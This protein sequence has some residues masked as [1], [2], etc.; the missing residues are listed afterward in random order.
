[1]SSPGR[2]EADPAHWSALIGT[3]A[4]RGDRD[5]FARLFQHFAPRVKT[6]LRR[7]GESDA[8]A[9]ELAQ[10]AMIA[11]WRKA[12]QFDP[13]SDGAAAWIFTI[14]RNLRIDAQRRARRGG[15]RVDLDAVGEEFQVDDSPAPDARIAE[16]QTEARV[17][18]ALVTLSQEQQSVVEL[19]FYRE[20][21][22]AE[23]ASILNIP[24]GTV[25]SRLRLAM[26]R[27]RQL[28]DEPS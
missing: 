18:Q 8:A 7:S 3:V 26:K 6:F 2:P 10:E 5:A 13:N 24:L 4:A 9:E 11:V 28:L 19:S 14:A 15:T 16:S 21:A 23:I 22:H 12:A 17:R 25:K 1:M 20:K 27:L